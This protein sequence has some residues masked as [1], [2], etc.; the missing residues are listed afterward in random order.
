LC[1]H[2]VFFTNLYVNE[3]LYFNLPLSVDDIAYSNAPAIGAAKIRYSKSPIQ[4]LCKKNLPFFFNS[5][6]SFSLPLVRSGRKG[7]ATI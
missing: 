3:L 5:N 6:T 1:I 7:K 4:A 2:K